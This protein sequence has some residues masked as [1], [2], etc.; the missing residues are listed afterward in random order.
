LNVDNLQTKNEKSSSK[1]AFSCIFA[2][3]ADDNA[4][5]VYKMLTKRLFQR[6]SGFA[7]TK[8]ETTTIK[9]LPAVIKPSVMN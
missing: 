5:I 1:C 3:F 2:R 7:D 8:I 6:F 9:I 4:K